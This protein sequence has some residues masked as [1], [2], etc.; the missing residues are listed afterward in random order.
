MKN[1]ILIMFLGISILGCNSKKNNNFH[2]SEDYVKI[3]NNGNVV[4]EQWYVDPEV[5]LDVIEVECKKKVNDI[6]LSTEN[7]AMKFSVKSGD[8]I[9][10]YMIKK[11]KD[12]ALTR[13]VGIKPI[14]NFTEDYINANKNKISVAIPEVSE[15]ANILIAL[16]KDATKDRYMTDSST[17]YYER[18][19]TYFEPYLDHPIMDTIQKYVN[20]LRYI[21]S[22][23]DSLFSNES[24]SYYYSLKMNAC[25]FEFTSDNTIR[26]QGF[27]RDMAYSWN[28]FNAMKDSLLIED[29]AKTSNFRA[30][31]KSEQDYYTKLIEDYKSLNPIDVMKQWLDQKFGFTYDNFTIYFSPLVSGSHAAQNFE[32]ND[33]KQTIMFIAKSKSNDTIS[34]IQNSIGDSRVVFTEIDHN[35]VNPTSDK[36][37]KEIDIAF[38]DKTKW[39]KGAVME[40]YTN[41][42][43]I[44][45]EYM[46]FGMFSLY[47][48]D[49]YGSEELEMFLSKMEHLM[50][51][52]RGFYR[53]KAFNQKLLDIHKKQPDM[54]INNLYKII[55]DW[56]KQAEFSE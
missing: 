32:D 39:A 26:N 28:A 5:A 22:V 53:F 51:D 2:I 1:Y 4:V 23:N 18:V 10:F 42:Y 38:A 8:T 27:V 15:L 20:G 52:L 21:E 48:Y 24:Y 17:K 33:F 54:D 45:N 6:I 37:L 43:Q 3:S 41:A 35:Y 46:T 55:L 30:F 31:Y 29:F 40:T 56:S 49:I 9:E 7:K 19:K 25:A 44:F 14:L 47:V 12:S 13:I 50:E 36:Y 16:H 11:Q 34:P